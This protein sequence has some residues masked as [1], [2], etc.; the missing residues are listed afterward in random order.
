MKIKHIS[1]SQSF[2]SIVCVELLCQEQTFHVLWYKLTLSLILGKLQMVLMVILMNQ[3][4]MVT[5]FFI[6]HVSMVIWPVSRSD[7]LYQP[8]ELVYIFISL[9]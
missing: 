1:V 9:L 5:L 7:H 3:W 2:W 4:K 8:N 6:S